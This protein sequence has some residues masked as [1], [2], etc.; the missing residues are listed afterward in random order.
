MLTFGLSKG[1][2]DSV[3]HSLRLRPVH[4]LLRAVLLVSLALEFPGE[5]LLAVLAGIH[6][7]A[8]GLLSQVCASSSALVSKVLAQ[9][10]HTKVVAITSASTG[11]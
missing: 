6:S 11:S 7:Y 8:A 4:W 2:M 3:Y 9:R 5:G 1:G 10:K